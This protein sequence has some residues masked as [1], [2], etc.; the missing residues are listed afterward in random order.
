VTTNPQ[1]PPPPTLEQMQ[2]LWAA[3]VAWRDEHEPLAVESI[4]QMDN[5]VLALPELGEAVCA[6]IGYAQYEDQP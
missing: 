5:V 3:C 4:Y 6:V 1:A 2:K